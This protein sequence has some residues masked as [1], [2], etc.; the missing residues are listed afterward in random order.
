MAT[1]E[2][3][4]DERTFVQTGLVQRILGFGWRLQQMGT[5]NAPPVRMWGLTT[6]KDFGYPLARGK[7]CRHT[8]GCDPQ[9][10]DLPAARSPEAKQERAP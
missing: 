8:T 6:G 3:M 5:E 4:K 7:I 10:C 9:A 2:R 1:V